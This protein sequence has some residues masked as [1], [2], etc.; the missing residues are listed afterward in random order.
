[1][2]LKSGFLLLLIMVL[3]AATNCYAQQQNA[4]KDRVMGKYVT[5]N[6]HLLK[7]GSSFQ[8]QDEAK[9]EEKDSRAYVLKR[10]EE[11]EASLRD[12]TRREVIQEK[13]S[14]KKKKSEIASDKYYYEKTANEELKRKKM[15]GLSEEE[16]EIEV[17][18]R[19]QTE[20]DLRNFGSDF[21]DRGELVQNNLLA[22]SAPSN[23][24]LGP[25]DELK[26]IVWSEFGDET[27]YEV[28]V[29][30]EGQVYVPILGVMGV[31]G[32]T[33]GQFEEAVLGSLAGKFKHFKGQVTLTQV[34]TIQI[35][36]VGEVQKPGALTVSGLTTAFAGLYQ[37]G[38]PTDRGSMRRIKVL[39]PNGKSKELDLYRYFL[40]GNRNHDISLK[41]GDTVFVPAIDN[42]VRVQGM[43]LRPAIYEIFKGDS[44]ADVLAMAG[45]A[46]SKAYSGRVKVVRWTG[47]QRRKTFDV[48]LG[49]LQELKN[50][51]VKSGDE[52]TVEKAIETVGN[53]VTIEGAVKKPGEYAVTDNLYVADL[54][55]RA[56]GLVVEEASKRFGQIIR[57]GAADSEEIITFNTRFAL[58]GDK[59][60]N[61]LLQPLDRVRIFTQE[62]VVADIKF[63]NI[64]GAVRRA[65]EYIYRDGMK[66]ADLILKA[67]GFSIDSSGEVEIARIDGNEVDIVRVNALEAFKNPDS[68][69]NVALKPLDRISVL[70]KGDRLVEAE[71]VVLKGQVRRPGP[72]ALKYRGEPLSSV[73][74]R[75]GGLTRRAFPE[76]AVFMRRVEHVANNKQL[77]TASEVQSEMFRQ[78]T[79]DLR[80]DLLRSGAKLQSLNQVRSEVEGG[81]R[82]SDQMLSQELPDQTGSI[83]E[84][85]SE[86][87][88]SDFGGMVMTSRGLKNKMLRIPVPLKKI[89]EGK[90]DDYEDIALLDGDQ[91]TIP[92]IPNTVTV[93]GA[94]VNPTTLLFKPGNSSRSYINRAG[95]FS[96][97]SNHRKT[98]V[99]RAN[100]EVMQMRHVRHI[101][102][103]DMILV[104]PKARLV[105]PDKMKQWSNL[106]GILGNLAV[107]Y[108]VVDDTN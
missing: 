3:L 71:V 18:K 17:E 40:T 44:L 8:S 87:Q 53:T 9:Q 35:Y 64:D 105:R 47:N 104:P 25:G 72:Y 99:V 91:I 67:R 14:Q 101:K 79:L 65:G 11:L 23:Y 98:V 93:L 13:L 102:R 15:D 63:V 16:I 48:S 26:I 69:Q 50:F 61:K 56:G 41:N 33:V 106:A 31:S 10:L 20:T 76:G 66:I 86:A 103:G 60:E 84:N 75:A 38:G 90:A 78:A 12:K 4:G 43:V 68:D 49:N 7:S 45:N 73:I 19:L 57:T 34:R 85:S 81:K 83:V 46:L 97:Y 1:M 96:H 42:S 74:E 62:E 108:K 92:V 89:A 70:S 55:K 22:G 80:A 2:K 95:G 28:Q 107:T 29:N 27:V 39:R 82:I 37:A 58:I 51:I 21:F 5:A 94:V 88:E 24:Q 100:G 36:V 30:P 54:I 52:I 77:E 6:G 32:L 59:K